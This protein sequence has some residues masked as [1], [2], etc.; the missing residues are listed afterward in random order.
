MNRPDIGSVAT[1]GAAAAD[2]G[3]PDDLSTGAMPEVPASNISCNQ[4]RICASSC[5]T[6]ACVDA[7]VQRGTTAAQRLFADWAACVDPMCSDPGDITCRCEA[8]CYG[9][10]ACESQTDACAG[11]EVDYVCDQLCH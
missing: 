10:S 3:G 9:G 5:T 6:A 11:D 8:A 1:G 7:C 2:D 4:I